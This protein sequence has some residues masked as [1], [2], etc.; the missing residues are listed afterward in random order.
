M[1]RQGRAGGN[2]LRACRCVSHDSGFLERRASL[3][4]WYPAAI[5]GEI[6]VWE[7]SYIKEM[8]GGGGTQDLL[9]S[10]QYDFC[11]PSRARS[12]GRCNS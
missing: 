8:A 1:E 11:V 5:F 10:L 12:Q 7:V 2:V 6:L 4:V 3:I 9:K